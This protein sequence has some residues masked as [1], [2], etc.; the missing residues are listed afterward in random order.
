MTEMLLHFTAVK[1]QKKKTVEIEPRSK[2]FTQDEINLLLHLVKKNQI[3]W[4]SKRPIGIA[5]IKRIKLGVKSKANSMQLAKC[6]SG[7]GRSL[8]LNT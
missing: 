8:R 3:F 7:H 6:S 2:N 1:K 4:S 5:Q